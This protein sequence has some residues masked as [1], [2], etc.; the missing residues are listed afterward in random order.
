MNV[1]I[2]INNPWQENTYLLYDETGEAVII[3][4]GCYNNDEQN[5]IKLFIQENN[6]KLVKLLNTHLHI[7][8]VFGNTFIKEEFGLKTIAEK[9]DNYLIEEAPRYAAMLGLQG[10]IA[11]PEVGEFI[12]EGDV[13]AFGNT[14]LQVIHTPGHTP[15]GVCYY[16]KKDKMI[17]VGDSLFTGSIGR[18]DLPGGSY[19]QLISSL[20]E[21]I[22]VLDEDVKVY[23]GHGQSTTIGYEKHTNPFLK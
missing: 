5:R 16:C 11:P 20:K 9:S 17:F 12:R 15:G 22:I 10:V 23:S 4:C 21:K 18:T 7:D 3:D 14:E 2:F 19:D 13:V 1:K 6:L 8:H